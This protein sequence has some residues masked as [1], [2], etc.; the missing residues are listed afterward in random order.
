LSYSDFCEVNHKLTIPLGKDDDVATLHTVPG[1]RRFKAFCAEAGL[2]SENDYKN[3]IVVSKTLIVT[4]DEDENDS[5]DNTLSKEPQKEDWCQPIDTSFEFDMNATKARP[6]AIID[7]QEEM[8]QLSKQLSNPTAELLRYHHTFGHVSFLKL[9]E[10]AKMGTI[11]K[12]LAKC[13]VPVCLA[14][15]YANSIRRKWCSRTPNNKD[16]ARKPT[17]PEEKL[18]VDQLVSPT[19]G[20][21]A[22]MTGFITTKRYTYATVYVDQASRLSFV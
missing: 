5:F 12:R 4:D 6:I 16:E 14:C 7:Y 19:P 2:D 8:K 18:S 21:I 13:P 20:L 11:P 9:K 22:Q 15:L 17:R 10:M 3:P 1:F